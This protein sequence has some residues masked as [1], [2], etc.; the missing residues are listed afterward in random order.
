MTHATP[1]RKARYIEVQA[2]V[3]YWEDGRI[4]GVADDAGKM[5]LRKGD[6]WCPVID[7][8]TGQVT[9]WPTGIT[10]DIHYKV[11]DGG[12]YW[13]LDDASYRIAKWGGNYVPNS[14]LCPNSNGYGD[15]IIMKIGDDGVVIGW[16]LPRLAEDEWELLP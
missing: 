15:Y 8:N 1:A 14:I 3:R 11:C 16:S 4:N 5:P 6:C 9:N 2:G 12:L 10:A 13:L 7:L